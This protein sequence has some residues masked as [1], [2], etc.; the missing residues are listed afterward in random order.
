MFVPIWIIV[1]LALCWISSHWLKARR[2]RVFEACFWEMVEGCGKACRL[3]DTVKDVANY[4][5]H[6]AWVR[7]NVLDYEGV[8]YAQERIQTHLPKPSE[9]LD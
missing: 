4:M 1:L 8:K 2:A 3:N 6:L 5:G 7:G 9:D